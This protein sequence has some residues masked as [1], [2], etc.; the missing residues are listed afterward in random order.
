MFYLFTPE[1]FRLLFPPTSSHKYQSS[2]TGHQKHPEGL[3]VQYWRFPLVLNIIGEPIGV[4]VHI[5][6]NS[7]RCQCCIT[8]PARFPMRVCY[9]S[10]A[11]ILVHC[12][13]GPTKLKTCRC[14][15]VCWATLLQNVDT[16]TLFLQ[17][18]LVFC[19]LPSVIY[20]RLHV[21]HNISN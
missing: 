7:M 12:L 17:S 15:A 18:K 5:Y 19:L 11:G 9:C 10:T 4:F 1:L 8:F 14:L 6:E 20:V 21:A 3:N 13:H 2:T 16:S